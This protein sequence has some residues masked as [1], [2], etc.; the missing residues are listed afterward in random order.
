M[1]GQIAT[2]Q[3]VGGTGA[4]R[5]GAAFLRRTF[6]GKG[7]K[8]PVVYIGEPAWP[9]YR[10]LFENAGFSVKSYAH[11]IK[12]NGEPDIDAAV[13]AMQ[14]AQEGSIF[15]LQA[16]CHNPTGVDFDKRQWTRLAELMR[17]RSHFAFFDAAY[18]G[19]GSGKPDAIEDDSWAIRHFA[20]QGIDLL[21]CQSFSKIMGLYSE[22]VGALHVICSTPAIVENVLDQLR[23]QIRWEIS[24]SPAWG[25]RLVDI[26]LQDEGLK[27]QWKV[28]LR[29][30]AQ[31]IADNRQTFARLLGEQR[32]QDSR[33][34]K[35]I[36]RQKGLFSLL[37]LNP[38]QVDE[39]INQ[40]VYLPPNGR[41]NV[42]G[43]SNNNIMR[44]AEI[45]AKVLKP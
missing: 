1:H 10:P 38:A 44:A 9:N 43:L 26:V 4:N 18:T 30:A 45:I 13:I 12:A 22:R 40:H 42:A 35:Q 39:L 37:P 32:P 7:G 3:T 14:G 11:F 17:D 21:A 19:F 28:E 8:P 27:A 31:R 16:C 41:I 6:P 5:I 34:L 33:R 29:Q 20:Q 23:A 2:V 36:V 15:V 24:S 25:A